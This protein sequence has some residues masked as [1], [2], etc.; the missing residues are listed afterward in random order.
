MVLGDHDNYNTNETFDDE[1]NEN[2]ANINNNS[3][4]STN[5]PNGEI[6]PKLE[7]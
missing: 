5:D 1:W 4:Q 6:S 2:E 3:N 7:T